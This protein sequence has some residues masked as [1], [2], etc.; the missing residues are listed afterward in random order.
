V[1]AIL[2][3]DEL[4]DIRRRLAE[5]QMLDF[6]RFAAML[7]K[8]ADASPGTY[9][10]KPLAPQRVRPADVQAQSAGQEVAKAP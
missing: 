3:I 2:L 7:R 6:E 5:E 8:V 9:V 1:K 10:S 4:R